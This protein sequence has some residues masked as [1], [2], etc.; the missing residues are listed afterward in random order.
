MLVEFII[1]K[2]DGHWEYVRVMSMK[3]NSK[4]LPSA[5]HAVVLQPREAAMSPTSMEEG[6][7]IC[8]KSHPA[9]LEG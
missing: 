7:T 5:Q 1:D 4:I 3:N 6:D 2:Q 9:R 8:W